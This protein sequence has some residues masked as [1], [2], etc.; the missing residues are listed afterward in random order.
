MM[1][2]FPFLSDDIPFI[3]FYILLLYSITLHSCSCESEIRGLLF[4]SFGFIF[5]SLLFTYYYITMNEA[6]NRLLEHADLRRIA[7]DLTGDNVVVIEELELD[8]HARLEH[9]S[10]TLEAIERPM[11]MEWGPFFD[12]DDDGDDDDDD[13]FGIA[14]IRGDIDDNDDIDDDVFEM[15]NRMRRIH[16]RDHRR[17]RL[18][19][20]GHRAARRGLNFAQKPYMHYNGPFDI[21]K[22][23]P[24]LQNRRRWLKEEFTV[25]DDEGEE[26]KRCIL[27]KPIE[28][29]IRRCTI[30]RSCYEDVMMEK[31][32]KSSLSSLLFSPSDDDLSLSTFRSNHKV[33]KL[34]M[35]AEQTK[36]TSNLGK[37]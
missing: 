19:G 23:D 15:G 37:N 21:P 27:C 3:N 10:L 25:N 9:R 14:E 33:W 29:L 28:R 8:H 24:D 35:I 22:S 18:F 13:I 36:Y 20:G 7:Y 12:D 26:E 6:M 4:F 16:L 30:C 5:F 32:V 11:M 34:L 1:L 2:K 17:H 31:E